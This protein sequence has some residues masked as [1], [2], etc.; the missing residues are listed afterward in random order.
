MEKRAMV[1][2]IGTLHQESGNYRGWKKKTALFLSSQ[3]ISLFG[4]MVV[5]Y[6]I[7]WYVTLTTQS[8]AILTISTISAFLPQIIISLFAG[9]WADRYHR[10]FLIISA[11][12]LTAVSTLILAVFFLLGYRE[13]WL[14]FLVSGIRSVGAGIQTPAVNALLPQI[15][16]TERLIRVNSING[17]I[18]PFI[19]IAAP[20]V[21]GAMLSFT[22]LEAIFFIDV[23]TAI[24]AVSLLLVLKVPAHQK[25]A[26]ERQTGYLDDLRAGLAYIGQNRTIKTLFIFFA[27]VFFLVAPVAFLTPLL[28]TRSFG[29][30][31]WRLTASEVSFFAGSILGGIIM[32]SWGGFKNHFRTIGLACILW[33]ILFAWL[34]L[35]KV[36]PLFLVI[37]FL[38]GIPMP[39]FNVPTT[40]LL[41]EMVKPDVQGRVFGVQQLIMN[42]V[43]P[44]GMLVF[45]P[46]ADIISIEVLLV[47]TSTLMAVP[48][49]W[50]FFNRQPS[51]TQSSLVLA[52]YEMQT[53]D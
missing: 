31:V 9:V 4:S 14:I 44:M 46:I 29:H 20:I 37:M 22:R 3:S 7:I 33:G 26:A 16:P 28:V 43:L 6:A 27:F 2:N 51:K 38:S 17:T 35:S 5:Q 32:T 1:E 40:T 39:L 24:L 19:M 52:E 25:A 50:I 41:Q 47:L 36:F 30:E 12:V 11:D 48:G 10:K 53:G 13:L 49:L 34:G 18:Q 42:T 15:V 8:G 45:G 23:V 21:S